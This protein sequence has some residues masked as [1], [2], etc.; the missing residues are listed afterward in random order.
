MPVTSGREPF[1]ALT[2]KLFDETG[3]RLTPSHTNRHNRRYRYYVSRRLITKGRDPSGWRLPAP[4]LEALVLAS[5]R[6]HLRGRAAKHD[7]LFTPEAGSAQRLSEALTDLADSPDPG[8]LWPLIEAVYLAPGQLRITLSKVEISVR[9][10]LHID[11]LNPLQRP[12]NSPLPCAGAVLKP[13]CS[14]ARSSPAP[15]PCCNRT[16]PAPTDGSR[17]SGRA[18]ASPRSPHPSSDQKAL[19]AAA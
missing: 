6:D 18:R 16:S 7:L 1:A 8:R 13:G 2:A 19:S 11:Q 3:D 15:M 12:L 17:R 10:A 14:R 5:L 9:L 4:Q